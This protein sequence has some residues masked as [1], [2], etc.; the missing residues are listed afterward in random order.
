[1]SQPDIDEATNNNDLETKTYDQNNER[2]TLSQADSASQLNGGTQHRFT[3][4]SMGAT[5]NSTLIT[6]YL[7]IKTSFTLT[8]TS[9]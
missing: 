8:Y 3:E 9:T 1:M 4:G 2:R 7:L 6:P 5:G